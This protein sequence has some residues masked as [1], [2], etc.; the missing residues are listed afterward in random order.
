MITIF[1]V[2]L[3]EDNILWHRLGNILTSPFRY[4]ICIILFHSMNRLDIVFEVTR[5]TKF[6]MFGAYCGKQCLFINLFVVEHKG[7]RLK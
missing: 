5:C 3:V 4:L 6:E 1:E 7:D 2:S